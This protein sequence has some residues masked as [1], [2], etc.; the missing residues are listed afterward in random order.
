MKVKK[1]LC[2]G[3]KS[4]QYIWKNQSGNRYCKPCWHKIKGQVS[5]IKTKPVLIK[6]TKPIRKVSSKMSVQLTIYTKLRR[7]FLEKYPLCQAVLNNCTMQSTDVH[8]KK[9]RGPYLNDP[10]TWLSV[11]R[12]CHN[13]IEEHPIESIEMGYS[14]NK[15]NN[16]DG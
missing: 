16:K 15:K 3:C 7:T 9:G 10:T 12:T 13:W 8:H 6:N 2:V 4:E 14:I 5:S 1:K 11:C